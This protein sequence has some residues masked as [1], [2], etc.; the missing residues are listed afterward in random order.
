MW[1]EFV[2]DSRLAPRVFIPPQK[3]TF[4]YSNSIRIDDPH[5]NLSSLISMT[6][7]FPAIRETRDEILAE[8]GRT[9]AD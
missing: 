4:S 6:S 7:F 1:V 8:A 3:P 2:V 9:K 5:V